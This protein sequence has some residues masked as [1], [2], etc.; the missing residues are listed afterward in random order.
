MTTIKIS[1]DC[2]G[3]YRQIICS[4]HAGYSKKK[5]SYDLVCASVSVLVINT[6]NALEELAG[7]DFETVSNE[8]DAY[9]RCDFQHSLQERSVFLLDAM[10]YGLLNIEKQ[11]GEKYLQVNFE[12]V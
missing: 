12:E 7:E 2:N 3:A 8:R 1:K 5:G 11:Y 6:I 4:G 9:I 10:V